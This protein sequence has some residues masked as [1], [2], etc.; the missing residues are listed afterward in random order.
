V[1]LADEQ[2]LQYIRLAT[3]GG[4]RLLCTLARRGKALERDTPQRA[5]DLLTAVRPH[6]FYKGGRLAFDMLEIEDL[7][8]DGARTDSMSDEELHA[9]MNSGPHNVVDALRRL[10]STANHGLTETEIG[11]PWNGRGKA[12]GTA[13]GG[14]PRITLGWNS[15]ET[16]GT[17]RSTNGTGGS[18]V[19]YPEPEL[20]SSDY[21]YDYVVLGLLTLIG[22][23]L[24][25]HYIPA[26][27]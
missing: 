7:I 27:K 17:N 6:P 21:L 2:L 25:K 12:P 26:F 10:G 14:F 24:S 23:R 16:S 5:L 11:R 18:G 13:S 9:L 15:S 20:K 8:L 4:S 22:S 19:N 1:T 3:E